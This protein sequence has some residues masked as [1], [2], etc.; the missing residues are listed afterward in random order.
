MAGGAWWATVL[1]VSKSRYD[2]GTEHT[3]LAFPRYITHFLCFSVYFNRHL[4]SAYYVPSDVM[5]TQG[6]S[7]NKTKNFGLMN[8]RL[9][10]IH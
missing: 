5:V 6:I 3:H 1:G 7:V 2:L 4:L 9:Q 8:L 10:F